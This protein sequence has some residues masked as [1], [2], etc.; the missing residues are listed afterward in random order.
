MIKP[1]ALAH[2]VLKVRDLERSERF[3][4]DILGLKVTGR[5]DGQMVFLSANDKHHELALMRVGP[6]AK[7][8]EQLQVGLL[9]FAWELESFKELKAAYRL[10]KEKGAPILGSMDHGISKG[11]YFLDPDGNQI[12]VYCDNPREEWE[13][14]ANPF[15]GSAPI[16]LDD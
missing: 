11:L 16:N 14:L 7:D 5:V 9:H 1:R 13:K 4:T 2:I 6:R 10:L 15:G 8:A 12:E 3:Y